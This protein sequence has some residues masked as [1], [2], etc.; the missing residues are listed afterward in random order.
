MRDTVVRGCAT[1]VMVAGLASSASGKTA[2]HEDRLLWARN[3]RAY[4]ALA[5]SGSAEEGD[6]VEFRDRRKPIAS[7]EISLVVRGE[8]AMIRVT[9]GSLGKVRKPERVQIHR[10]HP[11]LI[12]RPVLRIAFPASTRANLI[13]SCDAVSVHPPETAASYS[14]TRVDSRS[15]RLLKNSASTVPGIWPDTLLVRLFDDASDEE[16]ALERGEVD[17]A[18][19]WPGE[20]SSRMREDARWKR[21]LMGMRS[22]GILAIV[23]TA[24]GGPPSFDSTS[25]SEFNDALFQGDL[26]PLVRDVPS[27]SRPSPGSALLEVDPLLPGRAAI[28]SW[29]RRRAHAGPSRPAARL[30]YLDVPA[31]S[32]GLSGVTPLFAIRCP[33][34][35]PATLRRYL[36]ALGT[37]A[38]ATMATCGKTG[39]K[40]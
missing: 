7:G 21:S 34:V 16:I 1:L 35:S 17:A 23:G 32:T 8:L 11:P 13:L 31:D 38:L 9:T 20:L 40:P 22:H 24:P 26:A 33:V 30:A 39:A 37:D 29:L 19:F 6:L 5:D 15:W 18:V 14:A 25:S 28:E 4:V 2:G 10:E 3:D 12:A 27:T 36:A